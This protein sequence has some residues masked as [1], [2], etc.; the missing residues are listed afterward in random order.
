MPK[1]TKLGPTHH[2][3]PAPA[4]TDPGDPVEVEVDEAA[5]VTVVVG[6]HGPELDVPPDAGAVVPAAPVPAAPKG[7][8]RG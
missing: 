8:A 2:E 1:V 4:P 3:A 5:A 7:R 6:E